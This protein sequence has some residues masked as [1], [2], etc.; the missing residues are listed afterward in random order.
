MKPTL[1][2]SW[3]TDSPD[4]TNRHLIR[5][6][7]EDACSTLAAQ[8]EIFE[9]PRVDSGMEGVA[10]TPE[11]AAVMFQK[12]ERAAVFVGDVTLVG[13]IAQ[14]HPKRTPNPNVLLELGYAAGKLG[15]GRVICVMNEAFGGPKEQPFDVRN[16][17]FPITYSM[18]QDDKSERPRKELARDLAGAIGAA[19][20]TEFQTAQEAVA[21]LDA[22]CMTALTNYGRLQTWHTFPLTTMGQVLAG[23]AE[24]QAIARLLEL[25][26]LRY[27]H[28]S[29]APGTL[30]WHYEWT[31]LGTKVIEILF[32]GA[33]SG[34][35]RERRDR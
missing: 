7:L 33:A 5:K 17:R 4:A 21:V 24:K 11:V 19:L 34:R 22:D 23:T 1:F 20:D 26:L 15:W 2:Y 35:Q 31:Y 9:A 28:R 8:P 12:I 29:S 18:T 32:G 14:D 27:V 16:R 13:T 3:Q 10:G 6:A 25:R 30:E